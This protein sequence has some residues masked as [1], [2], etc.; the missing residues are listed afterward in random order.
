M[1]GITK[2]ILLNTKF[3]K[4]DL[5]NREELSFQGEIFLNRLDFGVG[6]SFSVVDEEISIS[7][8]LSALEDPTETVVLR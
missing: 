2:K 6:S 1:H 8:N 4:K 5:S 7:F 3:D